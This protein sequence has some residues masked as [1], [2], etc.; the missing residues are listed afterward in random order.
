M[1]HT[2]KTLGENSTAVINE[3]THGPYMKFSQLQLHTFLSNIN[4][5]VNPLNTNG[6]IFYCKCQHAFHN[7]IYSHR[8]PNFHTP[9]QSQNLFAN[10]FQS[11]NLNCI[12]MS[13]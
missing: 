1:Q 12:I 4:V 8:H 11:H 10:Y 13:A 5:N 3:N 2:G 6:H 9:Q 7:K